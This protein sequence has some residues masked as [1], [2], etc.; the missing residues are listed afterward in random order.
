M[1]GYRKD[2]EIQA[3]AS[4]YRDLESLIAEHALRNLDQDTLESLLAP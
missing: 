4:I 3:F 2:G 1:V